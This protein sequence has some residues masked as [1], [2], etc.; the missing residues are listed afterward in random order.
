MA[1]T[2]VRPLGYDGTRQQLTWRGITSS[3]RAYLWGGG[4]GGGGKDAN[5]PGG[6]GSGGGFSYVNFTVS[7]G[8]VL[9]VVVGGP[10]GVGTSSTSGQGGGQ[11]GASYLEVEADTVFNTRDAAAD[12]PVHTQ[13]NSAY[14]SFLNTYGVWEVNRF[15]QD[16]DR[17]YTVTFPV[18]GLYTFTAS[19]DNSAVIF[20]DGLPLFRADNF[21]NT[22]EQPAQVTAGN[23]TVRIQALNTGGPGSVALTIS[24]GGNYSGARGGN[25]GG[26][27]SS[28]GGGGGGGATVLLKNGIPIGVAGGGG[29]GGGAGNGPQ[30]QAAPGPRGQALAPINN[31]QNGTNKNGDGGGGGGGGGGY[32]GGNGG[33]TPGGDTGGEGG[34]FGG[35][36]SA[37]GTSSSSTNRLP[38]GATYPYWSDARGYGGSGGAD[39]ASRTTSQGT[40]GYAVV[41]FDTVGSFVKD[42][43]VWQPTEN[44]YIK[45][46]GAWRRIRATY[47]KTTVG[48]LFRQSIWQAI[49]GSYAPE[50]ERPFISSLQVGINPR[51]ADGDAGQG[52]GG[53]GCCVVSTAFADQGIW[54]TQQKHDLIAWCEDRLHNHVLGECFRRGYQVVGSKALPILKTSWGRTYARWAFDNGT[55]MVRGKSFSW[56]S[57][58]NSLLWITAFMLVGLWQLLNTPTDAGNQL[59]R[60]ELEWVSLLKNI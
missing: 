43:G 3:C 26:A 28:G 23:H 15:T 39:N 9:T 7:P 18:T 55:R 13:F 57:I 5:T 29:G 14:C 40:G 1:N 19:A 37:N 60:I 52:G 12:P 11:A 2:V 49:Q 27:G 45:V 50:F 44:T 53:G 6:Y 54:S 20:L 56:W 17:I 47:R 58:P 22:F 41:E 38:A 48:F 42:T 32:G 10:G 8:D 46:N 59:E 31:G 21:T 24:G 33:Q 25:A 4:G 30:G 51:E 35:S 34:Y 16:F 36:Y